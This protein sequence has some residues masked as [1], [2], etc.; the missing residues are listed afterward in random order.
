MFSTASGV[1]VDSA[2]ARAAGAGRSCAMKWCRPRSPALRC[3]LTQPAASRPST[4][5]AAAAAVIGCP[6][7]WP[8]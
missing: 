5:R 1:P 2:E 4:T 7:R 6:A 8:E 3:T